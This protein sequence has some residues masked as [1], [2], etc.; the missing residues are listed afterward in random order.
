M[1][2]VF[3]FLNIY[4]N[5]GLVM[6]WILQK[7]FANKFSILES[8]DTGGTLLTS[9]LNTFIS[10][11]SHIKAISSIGLR[12]PLVNCAPH[13][14]L[15]G[16]FLRHPL[17]RVFGIY[18][19]DRRQFGVS[20]EDK[21]FH[22]MQNYVDAKISEGS[23]AFRDAQCN[24]IA[25]GG[26]YYEAPGLDSFARGKI[27]L[28]GL[29]FCGVMHFFEESIVVLENE[30]GQYFH[31]IDLAYFPKGVTIGEFVTLESRL[32]LMKKEIG[33]ELFDYLLVNNHYDLELIKIAEK[34][35]FQK[36]HSIPNWH[37]KILN[38]QMRCL[39]LR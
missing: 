39:A 13:R 24:F 26:T 22:S 18:E 10:M 3:V 27:G 29:D 34:N 17:E 20:P 30:L 7:Q 35:L 36:L 33:G 19:A 8:G 32:N 2:P 21:R 14:W 23:N 1:N 6:N 11:N 15:T 4:K 5:T 12:L 37:E 25:D 16:L 31:D 9:D 28:S 38:L